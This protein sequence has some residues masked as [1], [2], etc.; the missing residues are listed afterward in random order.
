MTPADL[1]AIRH[2][3]G[4]SVEGLRIALDLGPNSD[5]TIRRWESGKQTPHPTTVLL[6]QIL[7]DSAEARALA[8]IDELAEK[9]PI[10]GARGP[11]DEGDAE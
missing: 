8:G 5:V 6:L 2:G 11:S 10:R 4:L 7:R 3:L 9:Y 1:R